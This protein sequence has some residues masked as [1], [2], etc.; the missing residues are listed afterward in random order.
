MFRSTASRTLPLLLPFYITSHT[1]PSCDAPTPLFANPTTSFTP[2]SITPAL[3]LEFIQRSGRLFY[4]VGSIIY[5][6]KFCSDTDEEKLVAERTKALAAGDVVKHTL[7]KHTLRK[8]TL[9]KHTLRKHTLRKHTLRKHTLRKHTLRKHTLFVPLFTLPSL[10]LTPFVAAAQ[11]DYTGDGSVDVIPSQLTTTEKRQ[12]V[13]NHSDSLAA[14]ELANLSNPFSKHRIAARQLRDLATTNG[15]CY[16]KIGQHLANLDYIMPQ[17]YIDELSHLFQNNPHTPLALAREVIR[18]DLGA[19]PEDL[20]ATF[21]ETP[22]ASASLAQVHVATDKVS[23]R[24]LA[25]KVQHPQVGRTAFGDI[26]ILTKIVRALEHFFDDFTF[27]WLVDEIAPQLYLE[28]DFSNELRNGVAAQKLLA[29]E[30]GDRVVVPDVFPRLSDRRVLTMAFE[31]A[32]EATDAKALAQ[33]NLDPHQVSRIYMGTMLRSPRSLTALPF[34]HTAPPLS[35]V[36][37]GRAPHLGLLLLPG[38]QLGLRAL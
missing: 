9:R 30:F 6:Y 32:F 1:A 14:A 23:G 31:E 18:A 17:E 29:A 16:V 26:K 8:H 3:T 27:G 10:S 36:W 21:D 24:K 7:R 19:Y 5:L 28:L 34:D 25:V 38:L 13:L 37:L 35:H 20:F 11:A 4:T 22:I 15:G 2:P 12:I 33:S